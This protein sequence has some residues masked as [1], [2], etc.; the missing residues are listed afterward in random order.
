MSFATYPRAPT[1]VQPQTQTKPDSILFQG[2]VPPPIQHQIVEFSDFHLKHVD[3]ARTTGQRLALKE[4]SVFTRPEDA[5]LQSRLVYEVVVAQGAC[6]SSFFRAALEALGTWH[7]ARLGAAQATIARVSTGIVADHPPT[8]P[9]IAD[10]TNRQ[11]TLHGGCAA[12]L[13]D[14]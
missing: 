13:V 11:G 1:P 2:D 12:F 6:A 10:M 9:S 5:K 8:H 14:V 7:L 4:A 3:F